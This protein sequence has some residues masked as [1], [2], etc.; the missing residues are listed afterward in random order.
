LTL[1][2]ALR[3]AAEL[4]LPRVGTEERAAAV[5]RALEELELTGHVHTRVDRLCGGR[6][7]PASVARE[8]LTGPAL[9]ILDEPTTGLDPAQ[10]RQVMSM[11]RRLADAGRVVLLVTHCL[12]YL[13]VCDQVVFLAPGGKTAYGGPAVDIG[14]AMGSTNW[15]DLFAK[16]AA[17][18]DAAH[19]EFCDP[20]PRVRRYGPAD[21]WNLSMV[22]AGA[23][24]KDSRPCDS[25]RRGANDD[26]GPPSRVYV[27]DLFLI[28]AAVRQT[29]RHRRTAFDR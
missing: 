3:F 14:A 26:G 1:E 23:A 10:D 17:D 5:A 13:D 7:K 28:P 12:T 11:L 16:V 25:A 19:H 9:L 27:H 6:R 8:L 21:R 15:A 18:P 22:M 20:L 29:R 24:V 2:A 4:R